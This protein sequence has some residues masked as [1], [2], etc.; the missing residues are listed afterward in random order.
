MMFGERTTGVAHCTY[1]PTD[2][3]SW[4][5][6][7]KIGQRGKILVHTGVDSFWKVAKRDLFEIIACPLASRVVFA[8][9]LFGNDYALFSGTGNT[10]AT[11][12]KLATL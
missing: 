11:A 9:R 12:A 3:C 2:H 8:K 4:S 7:R 10:L 5:S 6:L 1:T